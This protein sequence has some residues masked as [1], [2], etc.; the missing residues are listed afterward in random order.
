VANEILAASSDFLVTSVL[1]LEILTKLNSLLNLRGSPAL[2]D[3]SPMAA[4]GSLTLAIPLAGWDALVMSAPGE[5]TGVSNSALDSDQITLTIARQAIQLQVSDE[6]LISTLGG[7]VGVERLAGSAV[8]AYINRHNDLTVGLFSGVTASAGTSGADMTLDDA[9][10][11][12]A[13]GY[14][15]AMHPLSQFRAS[16]NPQVVSAPCWSSLSAPQP[17]ASTP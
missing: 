3:F 9:V 10:D 15:E 2:V 16:V 5:A 4:R 7:A 12:G 14:A 17:A 13:F 1:E 6:L 11:G 8:S